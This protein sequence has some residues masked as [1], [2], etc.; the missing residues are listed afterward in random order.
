M[1][2]IKNTKLDKI[3]WSHQ[4]F[5]SAD[6][7]LPCM[8]CKTKTWQFSLYK[9]FFQ[10]LP[11]TK[12]KKKN[13]WPFDKKC[14]IK[15]HMLPFHSGLEEMIENVPSLTQY[16]IYISFFEN[17]Q[18][19]S[20]LSLSHLLA[21]NTNCFEMLF[22]QQ[23]LYQLINTNQ[24]SRQFIMINWIEYYGYK[25]HLTEGVHSFI[26]HSRMSF[27]PSKKYVSWFVRKAVLVLCYVIS[28][29]IVRIIWWVIEIIIFGKWLA[30]DWNY[31]F[32]ECA[33]PWTFM[34]KV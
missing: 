12:L 25:Y 33:I 13:F 9:V 19:T 11:L 4:D 27:R 14:I 26:S 32:R 1:S 34:N 16:E 18:F 17:T 24:K 8:N 20:T 30:S 21:F 7:D 2:K 10:K 29:V 31:L 6:V 22:S 23:I 15:K 5:L 3:F 28:L